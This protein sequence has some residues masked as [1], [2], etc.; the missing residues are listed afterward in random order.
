MWGSGDSLGWVRH[1]GTERTQALEALPDGVDVGHAHEH[2]LTV[3]VILYSQTHMTTP[4]M[5]ICPHDETSHE[6]MPT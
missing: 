1:L 6:S 2:H 4:H 3:G 5:R